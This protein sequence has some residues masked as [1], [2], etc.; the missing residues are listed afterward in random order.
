MTMPITRFLA[1]TVIG[2]TALGGGGEHRM[3]FIGG[4]RG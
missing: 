3:V 2:P 4:Q 1:I